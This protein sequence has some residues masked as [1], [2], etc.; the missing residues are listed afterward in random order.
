MNILKIMLEFVYIIIAILFILFSFKAIKEDKLER[1]EMRKKL[2]EEVEIQPNYSINNKKIEYFKS[3]LI[4]EKI[5]SLKVY[6]INEP[7]YDLKSK[8]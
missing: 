6:Q 5:L 1:I 8:N 4:S 3:I 2:M 7:Y